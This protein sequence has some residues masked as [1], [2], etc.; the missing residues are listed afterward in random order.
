MN[1]NTVFS[2]IKMSNQAE[3]P[4]AS[5]QVYISFDAVEGQDVNISFVSRP[6]QDVIYVTTGIYV[7]AIM[8]Q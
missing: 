6:Q 4:S 8:G 2:G 7:N 5:G 3:I 1:G